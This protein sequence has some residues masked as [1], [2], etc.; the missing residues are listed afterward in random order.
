[1]Q[2]LCISC[3]RKFMHINQIH[4]RKKLPL[5]ADDCEVLFVEMIS[6]NLSF[7]ILIIETTIICW[8]VEVMMSQKWAHRWWLYQSPFFGSSVKSQCWIV[9]PRDPRQNTSDV[10]VVTVFF[11]TGLHA[12]WQRHLEAWH[13]TRATKRN[14]ECRAS[15]GKNA[16]VILWIKTDI[17][18]AVVLHWHS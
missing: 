15:C 2:V 10:P 5:V 7:Y 18:T 12:L 16:E 9:D 4:R 17:R 11:S 13:W 1:M 14:V 6:Q 3:A 8:I